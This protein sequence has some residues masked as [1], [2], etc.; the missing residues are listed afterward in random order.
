MTP[1][2]GWML[3]AGLTWLVSGAI[4]AWFAFV[5]AILAMERR[6]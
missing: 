4:L 2:I 3:L 1:T 5:T 6:A